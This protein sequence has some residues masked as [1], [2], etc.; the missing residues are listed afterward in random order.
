[1][2]AEPPQRLYDLPTFEG[3]DDYL[4]PESL[5]TIGLLIDKLPRDGFDVGAMNATNGS[6]TATVKFPFRAASDQLD[7]MEAVLRLVTVV[8]TMHANL[9]AARAALEAQSEPAGD[10]HHG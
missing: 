8:R 9:V 7:T 6:V 10:L 2:G 3:Q 1:M 5:V 4:R